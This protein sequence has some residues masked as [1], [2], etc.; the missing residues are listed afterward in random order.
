MANLQTLDNLQTEHHKLTAAHEGPDHCVSHRQGLLYRPSTDFES[1]GREQ[2][3]KSASEANGSDTNSQISEHYRNGTSQKASKE[4]HYHCQ[5]T[6]AEN[7]TTTGDRH[8]DTRLTSQACHRSQNLFSNNQNTLQNGRIIIDEEGSMDT[9]NL[10]GTAVTRGTTQ[11]PQQT[12]LKRG[13]QD[14]K[15]RKYYLTDTDQEPMPPSTP[16]QQPEKELSRQAQRDEVRAEEEVEIRVDDVTY[17]YKRAINNMPVTPLSPSP[18]ISDKDRP[19]LPSDSDTSPVSLY[20]S[21]MTVGTLISM[22]QWLDQQT[23]DKTPDHKL[24]ISEEQVTERVTAGLAEQIKE[25]ADPRGTKRPMKFKEMGK[26]AQ[27]AAANFKIYEDLIK[28]GDQKK[29]DEAADERNDGGGNPGG[30]H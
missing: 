24:E 23:T 27:Q 6:G 14:N 28:R 10:P 2:S 8:S 16:Q 26:A 9:P 18:T 29:T 19:Y 17:H 12:R 15:Q 5:M 3:C 21:P 20:S 22:G 25:L 4:Q 7:N 13:K 11:P 30:E 1:D